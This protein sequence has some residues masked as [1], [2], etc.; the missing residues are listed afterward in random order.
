MHA[1]YCGE[2]SHCF[3]VSNDTGR[4]VCTTNFEQQ[5]N[6][7]ILF[8]LNAVCLGAKQGECV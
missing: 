1:A 7:N 6:S 5:H 4:D 8:A 2:R 3:N